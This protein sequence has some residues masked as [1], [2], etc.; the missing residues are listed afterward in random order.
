MT[1]IRLTI[2]VLV[3]IA[4]AVVAHAQQFPAKTIRLVVPFP[5]GGATDTTARVVGK[6]LQA[7]LGQTVLVENIAGAGGSIAAKQ[8]KSAPADGY[9]LMIT[10]TSSFGTQPF[11]YKVDYDPVNEFVAIASVVVDKSVLVA[12]PSLKVKTVQE[13][14]RQAKANPGKLTYGSAT[15]IGPHFVIETFKRKAGVDIQ[16]IPYRGGGPMIIDL[17]GGTI[18]MTV[19]GKSVLRNHIA[20]GKVRAL[21]V[22]AAK[23]WPDMK[24]VPTLL[25]A[26]Y[27]DAPYDTLFGIV[28]PAGVPAD[29]VEKLNAAINDGLRSDEVRKAFAKLG[30]EPMITGAKE[31]QA[32]VAEEAVKWARAAAASGIKVR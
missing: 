2:A 17:L 23:R 25:E 32:I 19:N 30:I 14:V 13:L 29:I 11:L 8:V 28:A 24:Q 22:A 27:L 26:G 1:I 6:A 5:A 31:F 16:H 4:G 3:T 21:A 15:G 10:A 12:G 18:H 7:R 9:T 20:S